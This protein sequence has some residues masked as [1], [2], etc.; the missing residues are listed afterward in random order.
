MQDV[1][2]VVVFHSRTGTT[3]RLALT[4]AVG[5]VQGRAN[6]R[7]RRLPDPADEVLIES[8]PG[9]KENRARMDMEYVAP[10]EADAEW[11]DAILVGI[12]DASDLDKD[13]GVLSADAERYFDSLAALRAQGKLE[14]KIG[15]SFRQGLPTAPL[16]AAMCQAGLITVPPIPEPDAL[17][18]ARLQGRRV[19]DI[20]RALRRKR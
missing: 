2:V 14:G 17:E 15:A 18:A 4:A 13:I 7:L 16:Y 1:N 9:W 10:R 6:I 19:A 5:A 12:A 11:A 20:A 3:E 8:V